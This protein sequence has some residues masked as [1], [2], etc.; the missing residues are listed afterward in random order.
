M[1]RFTA[2][3]A[4]QFYST[5]IFGPI[6]SLVAGHNMIHRPMQ[7]DESNGQGITSGILTGHLQVLSMLRPSS[8]G[9]VSV[10]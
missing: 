1:A 8:G 2:R 9:A 4:E 5:A 3:V 10:Q 6:Y 7:R